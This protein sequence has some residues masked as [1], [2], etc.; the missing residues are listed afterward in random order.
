MLT[1]ESKVLSIFLGAGFSILGGVPLASQLFDQ[2]LNVDV[3]SR[4]GPRKTLTF[5][6][7]L[8][9]DGFTAVAVFA[10]RRARSFTTV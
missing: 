8:R 1:K 4:H 7:G 6:A 10:G 9:C 5:V 3:I 2:E